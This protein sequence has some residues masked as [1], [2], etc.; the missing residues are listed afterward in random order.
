MSV[1]TQPY[2]TV[3]WILHG[4]GCG[5]LAVAFVVRY[6]GRWFTS[7]GTRIWLRGE[8]PRPDPKRYVDRRAPVSEGRSSTGCPLPAPRRLT[9]GRLTY[10]RGR[11]A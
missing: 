7:V 1:V 2:K 9:P 11:L 8:R 10:Q 6:A 4:I 5:I 3:G